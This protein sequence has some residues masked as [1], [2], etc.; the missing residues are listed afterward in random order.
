MHTVNRR[1]FLKH[2]IVATGALATAPMLIR[3]PPS[4]LEQ[5]ATRITRTLG[6]TGM[7]IPIVSMGVM[8]ADNPALVRAAL[9]SGI[10]YL[11]TAHGYQ[12][13]R[14]EEM[15]GKLLKEYP[16]D[17]FI[18]STKVPLE[19][20]RE[21]FLEKLDIS[22]KRLQMDHVDI[23]YL[24]SASSREAALDP[25]MLGALQEAKKSG[26]ARYV[27][28]ST[29][30]NEPEVILAA[31]ESKVHDVVLASINFMQDHADQMKDAV[32][33]AAEA[34]IGIVAMKTMAGG[35]FD[36]DK[37]KP[38][39]CRAALKWVLQNPNVTTAIPGMTT[40]DQLA[41][42][43]AVNQDLVF[44]EEERKALVQG[45]A[46]GGLY[47]NGCERCV[48]GC[49]KHLPIPE[50]MRAYMYAY[51]YG[52]P[53]LGRELV[54]INGVQPNPC[55]DCRTCTASCIKGFNLREK[56]ADVSRLAAVPEEFLS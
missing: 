15:L 23:L 21:A 37:T 17:S 27:G 48:A 7:K 54:A 47:C 26:K 45:E 6:R 13:G 1:D 2:S 33:K 25:V 46:Q 22:L 55:A 56:I 24:H 39:N 53:A 14:N 50:L 3:I 30:K 43:A 42:N 36:R 20:S 10:V 49:P 16:R 29:H 31:V 12:T 44:T 28:V 9:K 32:A 34:G 8:R 5:P 38:V 18:I 4:P 52:S 19:G 11:D 41:E 35:F 51:G 40:F